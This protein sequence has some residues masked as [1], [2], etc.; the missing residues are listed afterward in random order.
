MSFVLFILH[1]W[2]N[3]NIGISYQCYI[4]C[5]FFLTFCIRRAMLLQCFYHNPPS[6]TSYSPGRTTIFLS[7]FAPYVISFYGIFVKL[8][9]FDYVSTLSLYV[10]GEITRFFFWI[11]HFYSLVFLSMKMKTCAIEKSVF[12]LRIQLDH[13]IYL[14]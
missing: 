13:L 12:V 14:N 8:W 6:S 5:S 1:F 11:G 3:F 4:S 9:T 10:R 7:L 2:Y